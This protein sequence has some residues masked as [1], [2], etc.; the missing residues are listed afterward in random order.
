MSKKRFEVREGEYYAVWG[1]KAKAVEKVSEEAWKFRW[2]SRAA[3][4]TVRVKDVTPWEKHQQ[5]RQREKAKKDQL[6][7]AVEDA[8]AQGKVLREL[9]AQQ[10]IRISTVAEETWS[11]KPQPV[12]H[13]SATG[14]N[15]S[16]LTELLF[17][18]LEE[19]QSNDLSPLE[20]LEDE[21]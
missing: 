11:E 9:L 1:Y 5:Q 2:V 21:K 12:L 18:A 10:Q 13:I 15:I 6:R 3:E 16:R 17:S 19:D 4:A 20:V 7:D 8:R 14:K